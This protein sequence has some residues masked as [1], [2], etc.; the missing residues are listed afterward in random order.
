MVQEYPC[1]SKQIFS[2]CFTIAMIKCNRREIRYNE[3]KEKEIEVINKAKRW[4]QEY[5][6]LNKY[7][8]IVFL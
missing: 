4:V 5:P 2:N 6:Y 7:V 8:S 1:I 3:K